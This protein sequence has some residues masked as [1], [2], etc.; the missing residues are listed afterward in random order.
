M[1]R[2]ALLTQVL[3]V[4]ALLITATVFAASVAASFHSEPVVERKR[5]LILVAALMAMVLINGWLLRRRFAPLEELIA[6][7]ERV[8]FGGRDSRTDIPTANV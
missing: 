8:D 7:M 1:K 4:N 3:T 2:P 5:F 6:A